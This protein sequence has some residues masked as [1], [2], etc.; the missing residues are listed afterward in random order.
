MAAFACYSNPRLLCSF[1]SYPHLG[2]FGSV[3]VNIYVLSELLNVCQLTVFYSHWLCGE[4]QGRI[5]ET[6][7]EHCSPS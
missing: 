1:L 5:Q 4:Y 6:L 2:V 3:R 7:L